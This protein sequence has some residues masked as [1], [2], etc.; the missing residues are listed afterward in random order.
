MNFINKLLGRATPFKRNRLG[1]IEVLIHKD[2][3]HHAAHGFVVASNKAQKIKKAP[4]AIVFPDLED[5]PE[6]THTVMTDLWEAMISQGW[7]PHHIAAW[8]TV[9]AIV[10]EQASGA[11]EHAEEGFQTPGFSTTPP[12]PAEI[13]AYLRKQAADAQNVGQGVLTFGR[14]KKG[15]TPPVVFDEVVQ[16]AITQAKQQVAHLDTMAREAALVRFEAIANNGTVTGLAPNLI[17]TRIQDAAN[18]IVKTHVRNGDTA[19]LSTH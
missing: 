14:S 8:G 10:S 12:A 5:A 15:D 4:V 11:D 1:E 3:R 2:A 19:A 18:M 13:P 16:Y 9:G 6:L 7:V 17:R